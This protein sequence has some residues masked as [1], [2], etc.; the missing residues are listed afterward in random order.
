MKC[1]NCSAECADQSSEC[2]FC[3]HP[4]VEQRVEQLAVTEPPAVIA[5]PVVMAMESESPPTTS[6]YSPQDMPPP[7]PAKRPNIQVPNY[8]TWAIVSTVFATI[9]TMFACCCIPLGLPSGIAAIVYALR[10]NKFLETGEVSSA[11]QASKTAKLWTWVTTVIAIIFGILVVVSF[12]LQAT[13]YLDQD[14]LEDLRK[15]LE[16]GR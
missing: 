2:D 9:T 14:Y 5:P 11:E 13:G 4:F 10:V 12:V 8:L 6:P 15:Q 7:A 16:A 1:P 3:G